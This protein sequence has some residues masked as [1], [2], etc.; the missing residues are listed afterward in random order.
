[1]ALDEKTRILEELSELTI[2]GLKKIAE[3]G[4][5]LT[6]ESLA[7]YLKNSPKMRTLLEKSLTAGSDK[8]AQPGELER[9]KTQKD[10]L[11]RQLSEI[12]DQHNESEKVFK[13]VVIFLADWVRA[14]SGGV[15]DEHIA[16]IKDVLKLR[17]NPELVEDAF[18]KLK[19][20][21]LHGDMA[22]KVSDTKKKSLM[23]RLMS[24]DNTG[25]IDERAVV[26]FRTTYQ[27]ILDELGLDLGLDFLPKLLQLGKRINSSVTFD[28]FTGLR[29]DILDLLHNYMATVSEDRSKA[30]E[31]I[32]DI[33]RKL[34]DVEIDL[35]KF[36]DFTDDVFTANSRFGNSLIDDLNDI[37]TTLGYSHKIDELKE[38]VNAKLALI[39]K[40]VQRKNESD[41]GF[42]ANM[43][44]DMGRL[45]A[46]FDLMKNEAI[47]AREQAER[48][49]HEMFTDPLTGANNRRAYDKRIK[50]EFERYLRYSRPFSTVMLDVDHFKSVNDTYGHATGDTCLK[51]I[52]KR[53]TPLLRE[54]DTLSRYGGEEFV[55]ILPETESAGAKEVGEKLRKAVEKIEFV[56]REDTFRIT[57][58]LGV[59][60]VLHADKSAMDLFS[61]MDM[62]LYEAKKGGR[63]KVVVR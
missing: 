26:Q 48:F 45:R 1:M 52:I 10:K 30:A 15:L 31:F 42:K 32:K 11:V 25:V 51:E 27:E 54:I 36:L 21:V 18:Q 53:V 24:K 22:Q 58:S 9:I 6:N 8:K 35:V 55:I 23:S 43:D 46:E 3:E 13:R 2:A 14:E 40:A 61:R 62:A 39:K 60:S 16:N 17:S 34:V 50:E 20:A 56:H 59:T 29:K 44:S 19:T 38:V 33:G 63:N 57:I 5:K 7:A 41:Q 47:A 49:E 4:R 37:E 12:E 28:D